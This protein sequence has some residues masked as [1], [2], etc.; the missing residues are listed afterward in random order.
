MP[1]L[2]ACFCKRLRARFP[3]LRIVVALWHAQG[4]I[5]KGCNRLMAAGASEVVTTLKAA[6]ENLPPASLVQSMQAAVAAPT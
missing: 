6:I 5:E 3:E 1:F 4:N 2:H